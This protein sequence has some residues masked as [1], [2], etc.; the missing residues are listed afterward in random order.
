MASSI[1]LTELS[2]GSVTGGGADAGAVFGT[3][4]VVE[5]AVAPVV[6]GR[7]GGG[8]VVDGRKAGEPVAVVVGAAVTG[9][10]VVDSSVVDE[11]DGA[12]ATVGGGDKTFTA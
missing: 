5:A 12:A 4:A 7:A 2:N 11:V 8:A 9:A 10:V 3:W 6:A 1:T